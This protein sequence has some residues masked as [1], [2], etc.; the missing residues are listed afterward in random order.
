MSRCGTRASLAMNWCGTGV[1]PVILCVLVVLAACMPADVCPAQSTGPAAA[2]AAPTEVPDVQDQLPAELEGV[3]IDPKLDGQLPLDL[4]FKNEDGRT[5]RLGDYFT[6]DLPVILTLVYYG[7]P[8]LCGVVLNAQMEA[9]RD[10]DWTPGREYRAV[11]VSFDPTE[12]PTLAKL[13]KQNYIQQWG[14]GEAAA[15]W[16]FLTGEQ[17][18]ITKLT[19]AAGFNYRWNEAQQQF[20]HAAAIIIC[21]PNGRISRYLY[22]VL[23]QPKTLRLSLVEASEGKIGTTMDAVL[24]YCFHYDPTRG[25]YAIAAQNVMSLGGAVT[26]LILAAWLV[27]W[28]VSLRR[29]QAR[30][31]E[32]QTSPSGTAAE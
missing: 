27:P 6:G 7:C 16:H 12:T 26:V 14:K 2:P 32:S 24:L 13:K 4:E 3:G 28:W 11:T 5:V 25:G 19:Q 8:K 20:A 17:D 21:T 9:M 1:S 29:K 23:Y 22:G 30:A 10:I 31:A 18:G 15:G